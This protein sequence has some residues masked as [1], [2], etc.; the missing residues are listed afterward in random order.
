MK[1]GR[2]RIVAPALY[3]LPQLKCGDLVRAE[4]REPVVA[5]GGHRDP[6]G[7][8][9]LDGLRLG[10]DDTGGRDPGDVS[11]GGASEPHRAVSGWGDVLGATIDREQ[12]HGVGGWVDAPHGL[13]REPLSE[14]H[15][16]IARDVDL[17][18]EALDVDLADD[19]GGRVESADLAV[20][21]R[22]P[23]DAVVSYGDV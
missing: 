8:A 21:V 11:C 3:Y 19:P 9:A 4:H 5:V 2:G 13:R 16:P 23:H 17:A 15:C 12:R 1:K 20:G 7:F 10:R 14:P 22:E 18:G 6:E